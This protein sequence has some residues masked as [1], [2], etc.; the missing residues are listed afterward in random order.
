MGPA[1]GMEDQGQMRECCP[2]VGLSPGR[3]SAGQAESG[4]W[5]RAWG[6]ADLECGQPACFSS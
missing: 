2:E 3:L 4:P 6:E 5:V 1:H